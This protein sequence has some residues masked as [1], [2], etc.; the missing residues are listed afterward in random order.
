[1]P[2]MCEQSMS[3]VNS[4]LSSVGAK[5]IKSSMGVSM[6]SRDQSGFD[7]LHQLAGKSDAVASSFQFQDSGILDSSSPTRPRPASQ[8]LNHMGSGHSV[9]SG[10]SFRSGASEMVLG[11]V[12]E[13]EQGEQGG[14]T[15]AQQAPEEGERQLP[16][17]CGPPQA[18]AQAASLLR[19]GA[20]HAAHGARGA[21]PDPV[22][23]ARLQRLQRL[24][25]LGGS[26]RLRLRG[27]PSFS[28]AK[29]REVQHWTAQIA[30]HTFVRCLPPCAASFLVQFVRNPGCRL[31]EKFGIRGTGYEEEPELYTVLH[32]LSDLLHR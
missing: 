6:F 12:G 22:A 3:R 14:G 15:H 1:M 16:G 8:R 32:E 7:L 17:G 13:G 27:S 26:R 4:R 11:P 9:R 5:S 2:G 10:N 29:R 28:P 19:R 18:H 30:A 23:D 24:Q 20:L 21:Q 31:P 25:L